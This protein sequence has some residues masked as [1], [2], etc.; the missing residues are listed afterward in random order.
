MSVTSTTDWEAAEAVAELT[1]T[2]DSCVAF[3]R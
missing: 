1:D 2:T 3:A